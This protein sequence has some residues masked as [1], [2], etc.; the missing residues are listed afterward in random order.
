MVN[1]C[2]EKLGLIV[3]VSFSFSFLHLIS[4][5]KTKKT[6]RLFGSYVFHIDVNWNNIYCMW[7]S[8]QH[9]S[10]TT[11]TSMF[12]LIRKRFRIISRGK[13]LKNFSRKLLYYFWSEWDSEKNLARLVNSRTLWSNAQPLTMSFMIPSSTTTI[14]G[15][16]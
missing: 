8:L 7:P 15:E 12:L 2:A 14:S 10:V 11:S 1:A 16:Q 9:K 6:G 5:L 4:I 3:I 13:C